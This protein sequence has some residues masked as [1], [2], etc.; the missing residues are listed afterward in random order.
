M[1][2]FSQILAL[3]SI[4]SDGYKATVYSEPTKTPFA[5]FIPFD[6]NDLTTLYISALISS[7]LIA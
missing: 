7:P 2:F 5:G 4:S 1:I 3:F 6:L